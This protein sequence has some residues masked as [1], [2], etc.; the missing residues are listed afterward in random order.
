LFFTRHLARSLPG[1]LV[2]LAGADGANY[3]RRVAA[4]AKAFASIERQSFELD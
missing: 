4:F 3:Y 2:A 1:F